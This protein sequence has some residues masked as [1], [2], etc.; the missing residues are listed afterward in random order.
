VKFVRA[1]LLAQEE[2]SSLAR[3]PVIFCRNVFI[4]FS[5]HAIRQT[6][7]TFASRMPA[8]GHLFVGAS[9]SL[10]KLTADFELREKGDAFVYVRI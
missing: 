5:P 10:L 7:A 1:N 3:C 4:Y 8:G 2:V 9:E 6:V